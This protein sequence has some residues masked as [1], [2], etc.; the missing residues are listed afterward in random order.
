MEQD[1][2]TGELPWPKTGTAQYNV[3]SELMHEIFMG[4]MN[5]GYNLDEQGENVIVTVTRTSMS[6]LE[7]RFGKVTLEIELW[8]APLTPSDAAW[9]GHN[10]FN[11][12]FPVIWGTARE[13]K[14]SRTD[15][16]SVWKNGE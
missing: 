16:R 3:T 11:H 1:V 2:Y 13:F 14:Q 10:N 9:V 15:P 8:T 12:L 5:A 4:C 6:K 7:V